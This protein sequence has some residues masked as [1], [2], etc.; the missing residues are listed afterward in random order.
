MKN[1][2]IVEIDVQKNAK[3]VIIHSHSDG[4]VWGLC[5]IDSGESDET[6][7][8]HYATC[9]DDNKILIFDIQSKKCILKGWVEVPTADEEA[10][11]KVHKSTN[12]KKIVGGASSLSDEPPE[13]EARA[14]AYN[15]KLNHLAVGDNTGNVTIR[16]LKFA[17]G[18]DLNK[19]IKI[20]KDPL[21]WIESMRYNPNRSMLAVGSHDNF[22]YIY[23]SDKN[24]ALYCKLK[25]H[26]SYIC[27]LDWSLSN[28]PSYIRSN[29]GAYE[30]LFFNV[31]T[32]KQDKSGASNTMGTEWATQTCK[33]GWSVE[34]IYPEGCDGTHINGVDE[35]K[36][37]NLIAT[38]DDYGLVNIYRNPVRANTH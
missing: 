16:E 14:I 24:Y 27:G 2:S 34:G 20:L 9:G 28:N 12:Q 4:E 22:I 30:L 21:E 25:G 5:P 19:V 6:T 29:D 23:N 31:D 11:V 37:L 17:K 10:G 35:C 18:A 8:Q 15:S 13:R 33:L 38:G 32:R 26:S 3:E 7:G 1:G 36:S